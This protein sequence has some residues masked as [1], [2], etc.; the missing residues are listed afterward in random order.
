MIPNIELL[1]Q[2]ITDI[3]YSGRTYKIVFYR[4][5]LTNGRSY[6]KLEYETTSQNNDDT[7]TSQ[8]SSVLGDAILG[9]MVLGTNSPNAETSIELD[10]ISGY[11]DDL[12][13]VIQAIYLILNTERYK[14]II[15]SWDYG[16]EL[17]DLFGKPMPYVMSELPRRIKEALIQDNRISDVIDF[18]F[19]P[20][21][22]K[23]FT[24]FVVITN[25]GNVNVELEVTV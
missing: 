13:A 10:R 21:R 24:T 6:I 22:N 4:D 23:L 8:N 15:Y 5:K 18:E 17:V 12:D 3:T 11:T 2:E 9:L 25:L 7:V 16:V 19:E 14:H 1:T 20:K